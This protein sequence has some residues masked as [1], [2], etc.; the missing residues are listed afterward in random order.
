VST[1]IAG[2]E[3]ASSAS[4]DRAAAA[5]AQGLFFEERGEHGQALDQFILAATL[6]PEHVQYHN[7]C[8]RSLLFLN[9]PLDAV[10]FLKESLN[11]NPD[12]AE[13]CWNLALIYADCLDSREEAKRLFAHAIKRSPGNQ[14]S[15]TFFCRLLLQDLDPKSAKSYLLQYVGPAAKSI[16]IHTGMAEALSQCGRYEEAKQELLQALALAPAD[17]QITYRLGD[18]ELGLR[19]LDAATHYYERSFAIN[20]DEDGAR[21]RYLQHLVCLGDHET[22]KR[23]YRSYLA[24]IKKFP[25]APPRREWTGEPL[26]DRTVLLP[27]GEFGHGDAIQSCQVV[28]LLKDEG[29]KVI[30]SCPKRLTSLIE[31]MAGVDLVLSKG[32]KLPRVDYVFPLPWGTFLL[33]WT[34]ESLG[35]QIPY[36]HP[37]YSLQQAWKTR[38]SEAVGLR[39]GLNWQAS[40]TW[41]GLGN[42]FD[43]QDPF[44]SRSTSLE[45]LQPLSEIPGITLYSLQF[46][47]D[48]L[49][50]GSGPF[51]LTDLNVGDYLDTAAAVLAL[52]LI[53]TVDTSMAHLAG[54]LGQQCFVMLPYLSCFRWMID[55]DDSPWYPSARLF[56]QS[57]PGI[58]SEV[59]SR[60]TQAITAMV[61]KAPSWRTPDALSTF[62]SP[63]AKI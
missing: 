28:P 53:V 32:V 29:A 2:L 4:R 21:L 55:R 12:Q 20:P 56:R 16:N 41:I 5:N 39:I 58:W 62:L 17:V 22:P 1:T 30:V 50:L 44:C 23:V 48:A 60:V 38:L 26:R 37:P 61:P 42:R 43:D 7:N 57:E 18:L 49:G 19:N 54:A 15:Y 8:A 11:L 51:Q 46:G 6:R 25:F 47:A 10:P 52:D 31:T 40:S 34:W 24:N 63:A 27:I 9:R 13:T 33:D 45:V 3:K 14:V 35:K 59:I 36:F